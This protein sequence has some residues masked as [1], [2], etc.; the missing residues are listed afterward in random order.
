MC[1]KQN[2]YFLNLPMTS[3]DKR[4]T[5]KINGK[6]IYESSKIKYLG[7][8]VDDRL[9]WKHHITELSKKLNRSIGILYKLKKQCP[10]NILK[11][12]YFSLI[13]SYLSYGLSVWGKAAQ[14]Y[15]NRLRLLQKKA[16][17]IITNSDYLAH[18]RPLFKKLNILT[19]DD[20]FDHQLACIMWN[21]DNGCLP[22][23][24]SEYFRPVN[25]T[26]NYCTRMATSGKLSTDY[27]IRT[28]THGKKTVEIHWS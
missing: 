22:S 13:H 8:I 16:I 7:L 3:L 6:T 5:L 17:R 18:T 12:I 26:H 9:T 25:E 15:T 10:E 27:R 23:S 28:E 24:L 2:L 20:M 11:S 4:I 21:Y 1:Q 14:I 19:F